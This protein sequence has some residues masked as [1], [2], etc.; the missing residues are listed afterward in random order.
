[1]LFHI[2]MNFKKK[3]PLKIYNKNIYMIEILKVTN[4]NLQSNEEMDVFY[5]FQTRKSQLITL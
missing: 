3:K 2:G 5:I 4:I 1:M